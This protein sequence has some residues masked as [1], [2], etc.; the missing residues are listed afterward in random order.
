MTADQPMPPLGEDEIDLREVFAAFQRRWRWVVGGGLLGFAL[1]AGLVFVKWSEA[2]LLTA[3]LVVDI[4]ESPCSSNNRK[5]KIF[6]DSS[7]SR[8]ICPGEFQATRYR[9][10]RF[11]KDGFD[12]YLKEYSKFDYE[13]KPL[14]F[15]EEGREKSSTQLVLRL[16]LPVDLTS[17]VSS[18]LAKIKRVMEAEVVSEG[19]D[20]GG[21]RVFGP[22][23]I[24]VEE[25]SK[26]D[27]R[28]TPLLSFALAALSGG[29]AVG[30][31]SALIADRRSNRVYSRE[32]LLRRLG[33]PL[34]LGLPAGPL[35]TPAVQVLIGQLAT[36]LDQALSWRVLS[37]ARQHE[38]VAPL[39]QMLQLQG[40]TGLRCESAD[41]LLSAVFPLETCEN[42]TGLLL[43][44]ESGFNSARALEEAGLLISQMS[45]VQAVGVVL[46][47]A[48]LP[49]ELSPSAAG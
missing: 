16:T 45:P 44:V 23:W 10:Q 46:I 47:G 25:P 32:E 48:P 11:A 4:F 36:Q 21:D 41:P 34:C 7:S 28:D 1:V 6:V 2:P 39:T 30:A 22:G 35:T 43:V 9:L 5:L 18:T 24:V 20:R 31:G 33:H 17:E 26:R 14:S 19:S 37:I 40:G 8:T 42:P 27:P 38:A 15:D 29:L 13:V 49:E 12:M 3:A